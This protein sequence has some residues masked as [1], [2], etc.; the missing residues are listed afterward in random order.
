[1]DASS[2]RSKHSQQVGAEA[3][4]WFVDLR[5]GDVDEAGLIAFQKWLRTSPEHIEAYLQIAAWWVDVGNLVAKESIDV[6]ALCA[7]ARAEDNVIFLESRKES[8]GSTAASPKRRRVSRRIAI[9][10]A[11]AVGVLVSAAA[12]WFSLYA[13]PSYATAI[14][15]QRLVALKDGS[16]VEMDANSRIRVRFS[17]HERTVDLVMGQ[18][19]FRVAKNVARPFVVVSGDTR[20]RAVGTQ[21]DV[22]RRVS[23]TSVTVIEG[24][25]AVL[26]HASGGPEPEAANHSGAGA[27][28]P[29]SLDDSASDSAILL[30]AGE[31]VVV[32]A[33]TATPATSANVGAVT[34][35]TQRQI[36]FQG[37][38]VSEV[39]EEFNRY[40]RRQ[41]VITAKSLEDIRVSGVFSSTEPDSLLRFLSQQ[42]GLRVDERDNEI[43]ISPK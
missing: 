6:Q 19:L 7:Q 21:F 40:N 41:M 32:S 11:A 42:I 1:M 18:A 2:S 20:V 31:Q 37:T 25:V 15:E 33:Q 35:W 5:E 27:T 43:D 12:A 9:A 36:I 14:G 8:S 38:P 4:E 23:R 17:K 29:P 26:P 34:A 24:R 39:V 3:A 16:T 22:Y 30:D 28:I 10:A 13:A